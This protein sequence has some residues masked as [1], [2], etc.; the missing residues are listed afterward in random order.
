M[1]EFD[2]NAAAKAL[3][4]GTDSNLGR[5]WESLDEGSKAYW[6]YLAHRQKAVQDAAL[7]QQDKTRPCEG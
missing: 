2:V 5:Y 7:V 4:Q 3:F 1:T 6:R